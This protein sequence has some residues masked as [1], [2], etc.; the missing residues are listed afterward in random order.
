MQSENTFKSC[1]MFEQ[2]NSRMTCYWWLLLLL[3][4]LRLQYSGPITQYEIYRRSSLPRYRCCNGCGQC[5]TNQLHRRLCLILLLLLHCYTPTPHHRL[6]CNCC[7]GM[8]LLLT[9]TH[10]PTAGAPLIRAALLHCCAPSPLHCC[11]QCLFT[12]PEPNMHHK[13]LQLLQL[14]MPHP[15]TNQLH[16]LLCLILLCFTIAVQQQI[17]TTDTDAR[18]M[19]HLQDAALQLL[20]KTQNTLQ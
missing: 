3:L 10:Q 16:R 11:C 7:K 5:I 19:Q 15:L 14:P 9:I 8:N 20:P 6:H 13:T 17:H 4:W 12:T 2:R 18:S 1:A